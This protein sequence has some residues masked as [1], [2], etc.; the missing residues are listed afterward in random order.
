MNVVITDFDE[1]SWEASG[2]TWTRALKNLG[3]FGTAIDFGIPSEGKQ[4]LKELGL[5][6]IPGSSHYHHRS[7]DKYDSLMTG[8]ISPGIWLFC[9]PEF[10]LTNDTKNLFKLGAEKFVCTSQHQK[11][12]FTVFPVVAIENR[13]KI[14]KSIEEKIIKR[15]GNPLNAT[16][17]CGPSS[18]WTVFVG[19]YRYCAESG[20]VDN[21]TVGL[22]NLL[23]NLFAVTFQDSVEVS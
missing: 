4:K 16:W 11:A 2:T 19:F 6:C 3:L 7:I 12:F 18:L 23:L 14:S 1:S 10:S 17:I 5:G 22:E 8:D 13:V 21:R 15:Y 20:L 9:P